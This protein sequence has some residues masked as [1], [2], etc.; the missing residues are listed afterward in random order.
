ML[1]QDE[2]RLAWSALLTVLSQHF[3][4]PRQK[5][6]IKRESSK[7]I[8]LVCIFDLVCENILSGFRGIKGNSRTVSLLQNEILFMRRMSLET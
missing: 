4:S 6:G 8:V 2:K 3:M 7:F 5:R 1:I